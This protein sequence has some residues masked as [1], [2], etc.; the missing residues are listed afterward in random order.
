MPAVRSK[1]RPHPSQRRRISSQLK[2]SQ[3]RWRSGERRDLSRDG[4][5]MPF[6]SEAVRTIPISPGA[7]RLL[8]SALPA[9]APQ[10]KPPA[11][12]RRRC[13]IS[14][15]LP[16]QRTPVAGQPSAST[17]SPPASRRSCKHHPSGV[18]AWQGRS[19]AGWR[20]C[21]AASMARPT[22]TTRGEDGLPFGMSRS[23]ITIGIYMIGIY[24]NSRL[25]SPPDAATWC[26]P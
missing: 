24:P 1:P 12:G 14:P 25:I 26:N 10:P 8:G 21:D 23:V 13:G 17:R 4:F 18:P 3:A 20:F 6:L 5:A 11:E 2:F 9:A 7:D 15:D 22:T 16:R 19:Y